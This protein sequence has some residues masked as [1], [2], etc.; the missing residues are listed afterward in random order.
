MAEVRWPPRFEPARAKVFVSNRI[1]IRAEPQIVWAWLVRARK[2]PEWYSNSANVEL[3]NPGLDLAPG[4]RFQWQTFGVNLV[5]TVREFELYS[6]L[7][8]DARATGI[9]AYHAWVIEKRGEGET[10]VLTEETQ[11]GWLAR[12]GR[13][14]M[15]G[16]MHRQHQIWLEGLRDKAESGSVD[17]IPG[18][19]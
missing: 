9:E 1:T 2:W 16:R 10:L 15:P 11:N 5:S 12:L 3:P 18:A 19:S 7:A 17:R 4:M 14:L 8:W 6:R 13:I